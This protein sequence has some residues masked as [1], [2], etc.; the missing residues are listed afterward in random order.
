[1]GIGPENPWW[2]DVL[3]LGQASRFAGYFD[4]D[5][6]SPDPVLRGKVLVPALN[7]PLE[8]V[9]KHGELRVPCEGD[10]V[11]LLYQGQR[12][13][14]DPATLPPVGE[15]RRRL[16]AE[17]NSS[18]AKLVAFLTQQHYLLADWHEANARMN[19]RWFFAVNTL[20]A[21]RV[22]EEEVFLATH[23][24]ILD[25]HQRGLVDGLRVDHPDGLRDPFHYLQRLRVAA[26]KAWIIVEK[27]LQPGEELPAQWPVA[28]TTGYDF[29]NRATSLLADPAGEVPLTQFYKEFTGE[30]VGWTVIVHEKKLLVL[31]E[32]FGAE[33]DRL[34][35]LLEWIVAER[36]LPF[37]QPVG[38][39]EVE[40]GWGRTVPT[41]A[42]LPD[43]GQLG[44]SRPRPFMQTRCPFS[45]DQLRA[46]LCELAAAFLVYRNYARPSQG[47]AAEL[48][49]TPANTRHIEHALASA[50]QS[51][52]D[53][54]A[55]FDFMGGP[56]LWRT[57]GP[58]EREFVLRFQQLTGPAMARAWRTPPCTVYSVSPP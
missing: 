14:V 35:R 52:T 57:V 16:V 25:W 13:P 26:P 6:D 9:L 37:S 53:L 48:Q 41:R 38:M 45:R 51:R 27:I 22:E 18:L 58:A 39:K 3:R 20:A 50:R 2:W 24:R 42:R 36:S 5:W 1:M 34:T 40:A 32:L 4:F 55:V 10:D 21:L 28:G 44:T 8:A 11:T 17:L 12:F 46:A 7:E 31:N 29:L 43:Q 30:P 15:P 54:D 19:Y 56:L 33:V 49:L 23:A 47:C